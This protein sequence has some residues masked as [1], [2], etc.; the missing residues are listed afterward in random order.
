MGFDFANYSI[1]V[2]T[3]CTVG[4]YRTVYEQIEHTPPP[5]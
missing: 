4:G 3:I 5:H 2:H 1:P